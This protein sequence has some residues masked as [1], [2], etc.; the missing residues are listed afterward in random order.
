M[1]DVGLVGFGMAGRTFHA[2]VIRS[3]SGLR[4][5]AILQRSGGEAKEI[6]KDVQLVRTM[7]E[8]LSLQQ[9]RLIV[10]ATPNSSHYELARQCLRAG[11]DVVIDK[12]FA[13]T[14]REA[15]D[16]VELAKTAGRLLSVYQNRRWDGDF[17]TVQRLLKDGSLG[18]LVL[19]ESHFDRFRPQ[20]RPNAWRERAE[21]GGGMLFDLAPHLIDQAL[22]LFGAP[23]AITA[24]VRMERE[25][26]LV[27]DAFD[28]VLHYPK[29]R[30]WLRSTM[31]SAAPGL[32]FLLHGTRGSYAKYGMDPQEDA[33]KR[34]ELPQG[35]AWGR[36]PEE[37]WGTLSIETGGSIA[38][39]AVPTEAG[40]YRRYY[41]NIRDAIEG[42]APLAVTPQ[43]AL[44]VMRALELARESSQRGCT[45]PWPAA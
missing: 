19:Y 32:R 12:P 2:P 15:A 45:L 29:L 1:I 41:E 20:L 44:N 11:K 17:L 14:W 16:L 6:Y 7:E 3:V 33:L 34:G 26:A 40:D 22:L 18:R 43:Q 13:I 36:E 8:M 25:G 28:I 23:E 24:E 39:Q 9:I 35:A 30:A 5:A 37:R 38:S 21:P 4:L 31:L 10:I 42:Q 27:D